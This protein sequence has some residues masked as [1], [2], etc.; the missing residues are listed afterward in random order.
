MSY[1]ERIQQI[2]DE[3]AAADKAEADEKKRRERHAFWW[4][5]VA[6]VLTLIALVLCALMISGMGR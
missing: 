1:D 4:G 2:R 6:P 5:Q 3:Q